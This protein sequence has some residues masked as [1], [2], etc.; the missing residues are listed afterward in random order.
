D[1]MTE[2]L[3]LSPE[4]MQLCHCLQESAT[5]RAGI[6]AFVRDYA[7]DQPPDKLAITVAKSLLSGLLEVADDGEA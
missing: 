2:P 5:V 4:L 6:N 3:P 1:A 7:S